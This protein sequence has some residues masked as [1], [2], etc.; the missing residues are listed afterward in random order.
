MLMPDGSMASA[1]SSPE[2]VHY[3]YGFETGADNWTAGFA[4]LP[5]SASS[6]FY[7]LDSGRRSLPDGLP[8]HGYFIQ[9]NNHSDDLFMYLSRQLEGLSPQT[10]Y[11]LDM[12]IDLAT[13]VPAGLF[14]VGGSPG[15]SVYVKVGAS[16]TIPTV[17]AGEAGNLR[18]N[19]DKGN[20]ASDGEDMIGIGNIAH[21]G[22]LVDEYR[23]KTL[24]SGDRE[25]EATT[26]DQGRLWL[27][28]GTD[29][30]FESI[31]AVYFD[32]IEYTLTPISSPTLPKTGGLTPPIWTLTVLGGLGVLLLGFGL[33]LVGRSSRETT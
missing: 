1:Q 3:V 5:A 32:R 4:D 16:S 30:G 23:V 14:G 19:V 22:V 13:N 17:S 29:S 24:V 8:G 6:E 21:S 31:T 12:E 10:T 18:I 11:K 33:V 25:F 15:E 26:D 20:Q 9:G 27:I 2:A 28:V 7:E